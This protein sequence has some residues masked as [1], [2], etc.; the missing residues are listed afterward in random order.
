[1]PPLVLASSSP[2]RKELLSALN[3]PFTTALP[4]VLEQVPDRVSRPEDITQT[5]ARRKARRVSEEYPDAS[6]LG[7]DTIVFLDGEIMGK[8]RGI[9]EA[10]D[11]LSALR[12]RTHQVTTGLA[13]ISPAIE[14]PLVRYAS[15]AVTMRCYSTEEIESYVSSGDPL[16]KAG[17]YA[18]QSE[19]F[20]PAERVDGCYFNVVGLP[21]CELVEML[22]KVGLKPKP[23]VSLAQTCQYSACPLRNMNL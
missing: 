17:A 22:G 2:R 9:K 7:A 19:S 23:D 8:P 6:V 14:T 3:I 12:A 20:H 15:T 16:D 18:V 11:M 10:R 5:F 21:V 4:D 13:I 1:M